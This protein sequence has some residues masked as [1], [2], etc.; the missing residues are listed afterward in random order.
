MTAVLDTNVILRHLLQ[1][2]EEQSPRASEL[3]GRLFSGEIRALLPVTVLFE[4]SYILQKTYGRTRA[5]IKDALEPL[6]SWR[7]LE[8]TERR[9]A[10]RAF[11]IYGAHNL[12][13]ADSYHAALAERENPPQLITFD[14]GLSRVRTIERIEH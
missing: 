1:D 7:S 9:L 6:V 12:S 8:M 2:H 11:E 5:A 3:M 13:Y 10:A 4:A 14:R